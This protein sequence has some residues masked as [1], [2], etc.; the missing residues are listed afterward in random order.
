MRAFM[1]LLIGALV[2]VGCKSTEVSGPGGGVG[3]GGVGGGGG[4]GGSTTTVTVSGRITDH[5]GLQ[6]Y[7]LEIVFSHDQVLD[8]NDYETDPVQVGLNFSN[9]SF[10]IPQGYSTN[11]YMIIFA[12]SDC[13]D[14]DGDGNA[15]DIIFGCH[16]DM[17]NGNFSLM[18]VQS[19][20]SNINLDAQ[21]YFE[22]ACGGG[23]I[24]G[25][26]SIYKK[27]EVKK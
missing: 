4:G 14:A 3:G 5:V 22:N 13:M 17:Q 23:G 10:N 25:V 21:Y 8:D 20:V 27:Q 19:T 9:I 15:D 11:D 7:N 6:N 26:K 24:L 2:L 18:R 12:L 16:P 1:P